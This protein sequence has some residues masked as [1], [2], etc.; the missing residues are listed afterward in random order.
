MKK[1]ISAI[2]L[3][4]CITS[5]AQINFQNLSLSEALAKG[6]TES[7]MIF[8]QL[9]APDCRQCSEVAN[10]AF[11]DKDLSKVVNETFIPFYVSA[12]HKDRKEIESMFNVFDEFGTLFIEQSGEL[13][14]KLSGTV[15]MPKRYRD[16]IDVALIKAGESLKISQLEKEYKNGNKSLGFLEQLLVKK[17]ELMLDNSWLLD[18]YINLLPADSLQSFHTLQ[19]IASMAP[20][21]GT[22]ADIALRKDADMFNQAWY[23]MPLNKRVNINNL[24]IYNSLK[25]AIKEKDEKYAYRVAGFARSVITSTNQA[26]DKAYYWRLLEFYERTNNSKNYF[27]L[28]TYYYDKFLM[29]VNADSVKKADEA[30]KDKL[31]NG[32]KKDTIKT[33]KGI[34]VKSTFSFAPQAQQF[35]W[36]LKEG[37]WNFYKLTSDPVLLAKA[38]EWIK[39]ANEFYETPESWDV[40][41]RLLYKQNQKEL[42]II[43]EQKAIELKKKQQYSVK[44]NE[45]TLALMRQGLPLND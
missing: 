16:E 36:T 8:L 5:F 2:C 43:N 18:E 25:K 35:T 30:R 21:I 29:T 33:E 45:E 11:E 27:S 23:R 9:E 38:T 10:K 15:S 6:R 14:H 7:K 12:K 3:F 31:V 32:A 19:F 42:A 44:E 26:A 17:K 1:T 40:Y 34:A 28:A 20:L 41:A 13:I 24:I 4:F 37:A 22:K 39:R